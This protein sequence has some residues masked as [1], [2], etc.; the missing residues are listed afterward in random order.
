MLWSSTWFKA[1][2]ILLLDLK[3]WKMDSLHGFETDQVKIYVCIV[4]KSL[5]YSH[6]SCLIIR[7]THLCLIT[8]GH[9]NLCFMKSE[10]W[11]R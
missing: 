10:G 3:L 1:P 4:L 8:P 7:S 6:W 5:I 11:C 2:M 9:N